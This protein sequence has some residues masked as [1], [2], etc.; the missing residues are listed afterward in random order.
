MRE[1]II[2]TPNPEDITLAQS[3]MQQLGTAKHRSE[4]RPKLVLTNNGKAVE[5]PQ[6][7]MAALTTII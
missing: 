2:I 1:R 4:N 7:A 5:T 6:A 3:A